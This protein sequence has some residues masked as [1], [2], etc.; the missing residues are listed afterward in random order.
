[1]I[2]PF[3]FHGGSEVGAPTLIGGASGDLGSHV[4]LADEQFRNE[5]FQEFDPGPL[6]TFDV[7]LS[8]SVDPGP[9]PDQFSFAILDC[10]LIEIPTGGPADAL[11]LVDIANPP[12]VRAFNG[13]VSRASDCGGIPISIRVLEPPPEV[14]EPR[15]VVLLVV[16][17]SALAIVSTCAALRRRQSTCKQL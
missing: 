6:L 14:P 2:G 15:M 7:D 8:Q 1:M 3:D 10:N 13:D 12:R 9:Q 11:V 16:A 5:F 4:V 17:L